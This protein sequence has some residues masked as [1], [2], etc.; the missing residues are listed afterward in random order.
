MFAQ[1]PEQQQALYRSAFVRNCMA[2]IVRSHSNV[3]RNS[4]QTAEEPHITGEIVKAARNLL[5]H[6]NAE[7]WMEHLEVLDDPPQNLSDRYG[8]ARPRIDIEFVQTMHGRRPRFHVEAKRLYRSDSVSEYFGA[9]GV[10]MFLDGTYASGWTSAGMIGYV[11]SET[12]STWLGRLAHG[13]VTRRTQLKACADRP[14]LETVGWIGD[15]LDSVQ[16]SCH[17]RTTTSI[18]QIELFHLLL[19]FGGKDQLGSTTI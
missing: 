5:E 2:L 8:K 16:S 11:Q 1:P 18:G 10:Q 9:A 3:N 19:D 13:L 17:D 14:G 6:E 15:G 4:L 12:C 7:P